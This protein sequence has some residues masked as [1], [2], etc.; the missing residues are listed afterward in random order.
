MKISRETNQQVMTYLNLALLVLRADGADE[1][2][3]KSYEGLH[4]THEKFEKEFQ[5]QEVKNNG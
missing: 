1:K 3:I 2:A 5:N 4:S